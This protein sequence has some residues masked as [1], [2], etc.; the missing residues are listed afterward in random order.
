MSDVIKLEP[1]KA[2]ETLT[3]MQHLLKEF[4]DELYTINSELRSLSVITYSEPLIKAMTQANHDINNLGHAVNAA[5]YAFSHA[6]VHVIEEWKKTDAQ[7]AASIS[8]E[9]PDFEDIR[10][11][12]HQ[13]IKVQ[14]EISEIS[15]CIDNIDISEDHLESLF[16]KMDNLMKASAHY[17]QG[18]SANQTRHNWKR[19]VEPLK[20]HTV[21]TV[22]KAVEIMSHELTA[23]MKRDASNF[24]G[25]L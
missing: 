24:P 6:F 19:H 4:N 25:K 21:K 2:G 22:L 20:E 17:W 11:L 9:K 13:A 10:L 8:F 23:F 14:V 1:A 7:A 16:E 5:I 12:H 18:H 3:E 15:H